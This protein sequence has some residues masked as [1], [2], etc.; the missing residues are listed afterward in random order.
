MRV[1]DFTNAIVREPGRSVI[2][3][4]REDRSATPDF[5]G[6]RAEHAT[7][8]AA[9]REAG[10]TVDVLPPLEA[11]PDSVFVE[12]PALVFP[13]GAILLRPGA[14]TRLGER[15]EM[16]GAL[17][18][19][20]AQILELDGD[21]YADGGDVL[22]TP[23][24]VLVGMSARTN[25]VGAQAL[26]KKLAELGR[27]ATV[28]ATPK[29]ILHFKTAVSLLAEDTVLATQTMAD[30]GIF[31]GFKMIVTPVGEEGAANA[32]RVNDTVLVGDS[33]PRTIDLLGRAGFPVK[34]LPVTEIGK[35]DAGLSC[36]SLRW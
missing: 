9:L 26:V 5:A 32:L 35:L 33:F 28:A 36:M 31:G 3:G 4:L 22:V 27:R 20:F 23:G 17:K 29:T 16:R 13:E 14:P 11:F 30:T 8:I 24:L 10:L 6:V 12:D 21:E 25:R 7:Y 18:R 1:F 15:E 2:D 19:H 34:P